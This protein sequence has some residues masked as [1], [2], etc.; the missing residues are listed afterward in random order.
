MKKSEIQALKEAFN[1]PEA[2]NKNNFIKLYEKN[3]KQ[4][5]RHF[6]PIMIFRYASAAAM[7]AVVICLCGLAGKNNDFNGKFNN[8]SIVKETDSDSHSNTSFNTTDIITNALT[9]ENVSESSVTE[10]VTVSSEINTTT[11]FISQNI[12]IGDEPID[13][14]VCEMPEKTSESATDAITTVSY[15]N[16]TTASASI[17]TATTVVTELP[18]VTTSTEQDINKYPVTDGP[19][20]INDLTVIPSV[21]Y[22]K[23]NDS[24]YHIQSNFLPDFEGEDDID[25]VIIASVDEVIYT[26]I[27]GE[28]YTQENITVIASL[29]DGLKLNDGDKISVFIKGGYMPADKFAENHSW[30]NI[31]PEYQ[32]VYYSKDQIQ[33][34]Q[35]G[36][37]YI[38][39]LK[40]SNLIPEESI[41]DIIAVK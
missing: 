9:T 14:P 35:V 31:P 24:V 39:F 29:Q 7:A 21:K 6:Y 2:E 26:E 11:A 15:E 40:K 22:D 19:D 28:P 16:P 10:P 1:I 36:K 41:F 25:G 12:E 27:N 37:N 20:N 4:N 17:S 5:K 8:V 23:P 38:F 32:Y 34:Q 18:T 13:V 33:E 3:Y 30:I